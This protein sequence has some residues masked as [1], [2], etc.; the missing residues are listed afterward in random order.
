MLYETKIMDI[1]LT[2]LISGKWK[3]KSRRKYIPYNNNNNQN[4]MENIMLEFA[5][6]LQVE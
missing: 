2:K 1:I 6:T 4:L 3:E 5:T